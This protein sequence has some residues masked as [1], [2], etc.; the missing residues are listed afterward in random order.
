MRLLLVSTVHPLCNTCTNTIINKL[1]YCVDIDIKGF[2]DNISH[3]KLSKQLWT[4]GIRDKNLI[5]IIK[6]ML[7][8]PIENEG[9]P[10]KGTPQ[11]G[12]LSPLLSN[13]VL[14]ELDWWIASQWETFETNYKYTHANKYRALRKTKLKEIFLVRY[15]DDFKIMCRTRQDAENIFKAVKHCYIDA[16]CDIE[17][18]AKQG[19]LMFNR[20]LTVELNKPNSHIKL[21]KSIT[22]RMICLL[23]DH[24]KNQNKKIVFMLWGNNAKELISFI[25]TDYHIILTHTHPSPLSRKSFYTCDHFVECNKV[26]NILW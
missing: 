24:M 18:W 13:I 12:I 3:S 25:D 19:V 4:I 26:Y 16:T 15:A 8:A 1:Q 2:F 10:Q 5:S 20:A 9:I 11:G 14:N 21:W 17:S 23:S 7:V 6:K 22:N